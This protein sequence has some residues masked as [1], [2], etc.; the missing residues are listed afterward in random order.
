MEDMASATHPFKRTMLE[1]AAGEMVVELLR[2]TGVYGVQCPDLF[3]FTEDL[4]NWCFVE[5][6]GRGI[7]CG[8][9]RR[10][11]LTGLHA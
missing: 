10:K 3:V 9:F 4:R 7:G 8:R 6:K 2:N 5:V 11:H 1:R